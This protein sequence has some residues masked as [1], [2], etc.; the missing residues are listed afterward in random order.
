MPAKISDLERVAKKLGFQKVRQK[1]SHARWKHDDGRATTLPVHGNGEVGTG[2]FHKILEEMGIT[3][4]R[5]L[6]LL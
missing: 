6:E 1:G 2:L 4:A 5:F 3:E